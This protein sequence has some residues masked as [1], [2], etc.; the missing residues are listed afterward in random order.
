[1]VMPPIYLEKTLE[2]KK[3]I[4]GEFIGHIVVGAVMFTAL[5]LFSGALSALVH[6]FTPI[7]DDEFFTLLMKFV[8]RFILVADVV[9]II[10]VTIYSTYKAVKGMFHE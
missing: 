8:E 6:W 10:W 5:L 4:I 1:M 9:F 7:I 3:K 2:K